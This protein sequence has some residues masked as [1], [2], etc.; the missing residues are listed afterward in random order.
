MVEVRS[1]GLVCS[2]SRTLDHGF[3]QPW[4]TRSR[5]FGPRFRVTLDHSFAL[6]WTTVSRNPGPPVT[7]SLDQAL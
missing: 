7:L 1:L 3:A 6:P 2:Y 5:H 4:T